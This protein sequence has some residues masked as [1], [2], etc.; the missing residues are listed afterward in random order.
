M[1]SQKQEMSINVNFE[2]IYF[3]FADLSDIFSE[4]E[5][6]SATGRIE[7]IQQFVQNHPENV[8]TYKK[9]LSNFDPYGK[10]G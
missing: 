8:R 10:S 5:I 7:V 4:L 9:S 2:P 3:S 1:S 6:A